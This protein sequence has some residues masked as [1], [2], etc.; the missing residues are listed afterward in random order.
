MGPVMLV[1]DVMETEGKESEE[2]FLK[3]GFGRN[4]SDVEGSIQ[5]EVFKIY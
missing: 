2:E 4:P 5:P 3:N 1:Y